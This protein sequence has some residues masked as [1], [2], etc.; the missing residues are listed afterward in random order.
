MDVDAALVAW[1]QSLFPTARVATKTPPKLEE[2]LPMVRLRTITGT[3][4]ALTMERVSVDTQTF[5]SADDEPAGDVFAQ[6]VR[7]AFRDRLPRTV[8]GAAVVTDVVTQR[9]VWVPYDNPTVV[10]YVATHT[11]MLHARGGAAL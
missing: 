7:A 2:A 9:P 4:V 6:D 8:L 1:L 11:L 5:W 10:R 3:D